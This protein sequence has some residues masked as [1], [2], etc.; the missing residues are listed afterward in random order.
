MNPTRQAH[1]ETIYQTKASNQLSWTQELPATSLTL[2]HS[3]NLDHRAKIID[4]G[5]GDSHLVDHL[6]AEGFENLAVLDISS[7][8]LEKTKRRLGKQA[9]K[10]NWIV[11]DILDFNSD[12][13]YDLWHDRATFHFLTT[14]EQVTRYMDMAR[15]Y[16]VQYLTMGTFSDQGPTQCSGLPIQQYNEGSLTA[17]LRNGFDKLKCITED[18]I[19]PFDTRQN[20]LFCSFKRQSPPPQ[21]G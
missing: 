11:S 15:K 17:E 16:V 20:F 8:A 5:G 14:L 19:T 1:W 3:L 18:H 10:V 6:I 2:I 4:I 21:M 13:Q 12:T 7:V 9:S